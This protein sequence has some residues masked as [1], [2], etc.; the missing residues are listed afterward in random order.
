M[1]A[2]QR[3]DTATVS[4]QQ[5]LSYWN[6]CV[7]S[8]YTGMSVDSSV[9]NFC[10]DLL[11]VDVGR[12]GVMRARADESVI[13]RA[14]HGSS[15]SGE[16][17]TVLI[18]LQNQGTSLNRQAGSE[19]LLGVGDIT[20]CENR[21]AYM[22]KPSHASDIF[23][24]ELPYQLAREFI[25]EVAGH[26]MQRVAGCSLQGRLLFNMLHT[27][28]RECASLQHDDMEFDSLETVLLELLGQV[29][30]AP[31]EHSPSL[32]A[33][34]G[35]LLRQ[36]LKTIVQQHLSNTE[37]ATDVLA[38]EAG[39]SVRRVQ[40]LFADWGTTPSLYIRAQRLSWAAERLQFEPEQSIA[41]IAFDAGFNDAAYFSRCFRQCYGATPKDYRA[42]LA[43]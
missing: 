12:I 33:R 41:R 11:Y 5:R 19:A 26:I 14:N 16:K 34:K 13:R 32:D 9:S 24:L 36:R 37:F 8:I 10:A 35:E 3:V 30:N 39:L 43:V 20:V 23:A 25:P 38:N 27:I 18:H 28:Y 31:R 42:K 22:I 29:L 21:S 6:N 7:G 15:V 17:D 2:I 40:A 1:A 4:P